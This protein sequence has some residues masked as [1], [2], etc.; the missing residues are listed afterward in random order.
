[1]PSFP[2]VPI[3]LT[4]T[5]SEIPQWLI[6]DLRPLASGERSWNV[7]DS[8]LE[9]SRVRASQVLDP[10]WYG[11]VASNPRTEV[12]RL[13]KT[14]GVAVVPVHPMRVERDRLE[15]NEHFAAIMAEADRI[16]HQEAGETANAMGGCHL[17]WRIK[18]RVLKEDFGLDWRSPSELNPD[19]LFD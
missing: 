18:K 6:D 3:C 1:M 11:R 14:A 7:W 13:L 4:N 10:K 8:W 9:M 2:G 12:L 5:R 17:V 15:D 16:A 19:V